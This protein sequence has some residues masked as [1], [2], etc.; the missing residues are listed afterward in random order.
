MIPDARIN[1]QT[2]ERLRLKI[3]SRKGDTLYF[4]T[5]KQEL[6]KYDGLKKIDVN[7]VTSSIL[8]VHT[9]ADF[10]EIIHYAEEKKLFKIDKSV[11]PANT[12]S[13]VVIGGF[14]YINKMIKGLTKRELDLPLAAFLVLVGVAIY[15]I[16]RGNFRAPAWYTA[17]WYGMNIF[18][19]AMASRDKE[20]D[21]HS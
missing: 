7:H 11:V 3:P 8:I 1:H 14:H 13:E 10:N 4:L 19:K 16:A 15:Q 21:G 17:L 20:D 12:V 5:L 18:L 6:S 2:S 9:E